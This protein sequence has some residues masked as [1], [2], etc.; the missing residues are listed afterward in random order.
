VSKE[1]SVGLLVLLQSV[2]EACSYPCETKPGMGR[3][4]LKDASL[5]C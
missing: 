3:P 1:I 2:G 4:A 5:S